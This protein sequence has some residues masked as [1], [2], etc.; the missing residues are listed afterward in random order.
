MFEIKQLLKNYY[1]DDAHNDIGIVHIFTS[2]PVYLIF[3]DKDFPDYII[4]KLEQ[5]QAHYLFDLC[6]ELYVYLQDIIAKPLDVID[7]NAD[8][9]FIEE[10]VEGDPWFQIK[11]K[12]KSLDDW[13]KLNLACIS[14]I[15]DFHIKISKN[16]KWNANI[17]LGDELTQIYQNIKLT[18]NEVNQSLGNLV[19]RYSDQLRK[20][21]DMNINYQHGDYS[22]NNVMVNNSK[23][24]IIDLED[25]GRVS[26]PLFDE[27]SYAIS[28]Y[29]Q[30][31]SDIQPNLWLLIDECCHLK[32]KRIGYDRQII[33]SAVLFTLMFRLGSW[34]QSIKRQDFRSKI[35]VMLND[36]ID[37]NSDV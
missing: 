29:I 11:S 15:D 19:I 34:S 33:N 2:N 12:L 5:K 28:I 13:N 7:I 17:N 27:I 10:G 26:F 23:V 3:L 30:M 8:G 16:P 20:L 24:I 31:P 1:S 22:I 32:V 35:I 21:G 14:A 37:I 6:Q 36:F 25:F 4:R 9:Y 18:G